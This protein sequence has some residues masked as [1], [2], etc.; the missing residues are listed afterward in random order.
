MESIRSELSW[1]AQDYKEAG[2]DVPELLVDNPLQCEGEL[3]ADWEVEDYV[4]DSVAT[5]SI[6]V[7]KR[8][9]SFDRVF[10]QFVADLDFLFKIGRIKE[11]DYNELIDEN[12][13]GF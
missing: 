8:S 1:T 6:L 13:Y 2:R 4:T 3:M 9:G 12:S 7:D 10:K 11:D 5:L